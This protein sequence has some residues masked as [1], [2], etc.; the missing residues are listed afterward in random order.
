MLEYAAQDKGYFV[1]QIFFRQASHIEVMRCNE[2][3]PVLLLTWQAKDL[4]SSLRTFFESQGVYPVVVY[5]VRG[6]AFLC[7]KF[8][9]IQGRI[10]TKIS[11]NNLIE[12]TAT[13]EHLEAKLA[14]SVI[15]KKRISGFF[16]PFFWLSSTSY[17]VEINNI[18]EV[19]I[20]QSDHHLWYELTKHKTKNYGGLN[21]KTIQFLQVLYGQY[22]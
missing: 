19:T 5:D 2:E 8:F 17:V 18:L 14:E 6:R 3:K 13:I 15:T 11:L 21:G 1:V 4:P 12:W 7:Y 22:Q 9:R 20:W 16:S 10:W